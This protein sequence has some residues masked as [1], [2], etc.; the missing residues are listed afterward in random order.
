[1]LVVEFCP[2]SGIFVP[3]RAHVHREALVDGKCMALNLREKEKRRDNSDASH[4]ES[5]RSVSA[6]DGSTTEGICAGALNE[7]R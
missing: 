2:R 1:M 7:F 4:N 5:S 3:D 6:K